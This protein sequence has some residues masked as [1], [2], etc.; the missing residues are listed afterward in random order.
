[1]VCRGFKGI[2]GSRSYQWGSTSHQTFSRH[3]EALAWGRWY[4]LK[5]ENFKV[6][7][8][9]FGCCSLSRSSYKWDFRVKLRG[10]RWVETSLSLQSPKVGLSQRHAV[11]HKSQCP[12]FSCCG[13]HSPCGIMS[14]RPSDSKA[15]FALWCDC[16]KRTS[17]LEWPRAPRTES[18]HLMLWRPLCLHQS[19]SSV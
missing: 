13:A 19:P 11:C 18:S 5:D 12:L 8:I 4:R 9:L 7:R 14:M 1:M 15:G 17:S 3:A 10:K 16:Q 2:G 6:N